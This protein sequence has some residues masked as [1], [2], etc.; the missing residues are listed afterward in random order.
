[1]PETE[2]VT[3][4]PR[5]RQERLRI[6]EVELN[7]GGRIEASPHTAGITLERLVTEAGADVIRVQVGKDPDWLDIP[8]WMVCEVRYVAGDTF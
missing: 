1:L 6:T 5:P 3:H 8:T 4:A 7:N 2:R